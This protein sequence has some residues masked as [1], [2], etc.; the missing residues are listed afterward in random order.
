MMIDATSITPWNNNACSMH[1]YA[2]LKRALIWM[3]QSL[4]SWMKN[5]ILLCFLQWRIGGGGGGIIR[6]PFGVCCCCAFHP[7]GLSDRRTIPPPHNV[8]V[9]Q[10]RNSGGGGGNMSDSPP[11]PPPPLN[12]LAQHRGICIPGPP[13]S[14]ILHPPLFYAI[15]CESLY[16]QHSHFETVFVLDIWYK[17]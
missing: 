4:L 1:V 5:A 7:R 10:K 9:A 14:Q 8:N 13:F 3:F 12:D 16:L 11:P 6:A 15:L 17:K 2:D